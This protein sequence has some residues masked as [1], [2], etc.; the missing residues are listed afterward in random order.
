MYPRCPQ[1]NLQADLNEWIRVLRGLFFVH[2]QGLR[3][4][5]QTLLL[6]E[7]VTSAE[8]PEVP[9]IETFRGFGDSGPRA[10]RSPLHLVLRVVRGWG[11]NCSSLVSGCSVL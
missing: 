2:F 7:H 11:Q 1:S 6:G 4:L 5:T 10:R 9:S 3:W 8:E